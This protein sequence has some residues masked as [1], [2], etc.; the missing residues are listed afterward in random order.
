MTAQPHSP[1]SLNNA[2]GGRV[3]GIGVF[4]RLVL[5]LAGTAAATIS[6]LGETDRTVIWPAL[7]WM[8]VSVALYLS[9]LFVSNSPDLFSPVTQTGAYYGL[10]LLAS[11]ANVVLS[12]DVQFPGLPHLLESQRVSLLE[13]ICILHIVSFGSYLLGYRLT[14][15]H[16]IVRFFP[17]VAG[18]QWRRSRVLFISVLCL[19]AFVAS[20]TVF[21]LR[22]GRPLYEIRF[23]QEGKMVWREDPTMSWMLRGVYLGF[24]P[25]F[26]LYVAM[27]RSPSR[28][29]QIVSVVFF[30]L[31]AFLVTRLGQRGAALWVGLALLGLFHYLRRRIPVWLF[32]GLFGIAMVIT[33]VLGEY[34]TGGPER[35][36]SMEAY[37]DQ[38]HS[39]LHALAEHD[40]DR[41][42][43]IPFAVVLY[44]F[45]EHHGYLFGKSWTALSAV[46]VPRW[47]W[48]DK[49]I[50]FPWT[51][52]ALVWHLIGAPI[53]T[54][55]PGLLYANFSWAGV[56]LGMF[57]WGAFHRGLYAWLCRHPK[58]PNVVLLYVLLLL[59]FAPTFLAI[60]ATL[61]YVV[62]ALLTLYW[63]TQKGS[64]RRT[65]TTDEK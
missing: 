36:S 41:A 40:N 47:I 51:D 48:P 14:T 24:V 3:F 25:V 6:L 58:D 27:L 8:C 1:L 57:L 56:V 33:N 38:E 45:P 61:Q 28:L 35:T 2:A 12:G 63:A 64:H 49:G 17:D 37:S 16:R 43:L 18:R 23:L 4:V 11:L 59:F 62:P 60:S 34:R 26:F 52:G 46:L 20:Y 22:L 42:R 65:R 53:P 50:T 44:F 31:L 30:V 32:L 19:I 5:F 55:F 29:A 39:P 54:P 7:P 21:Q 10:G 15:G 13:K 9:P